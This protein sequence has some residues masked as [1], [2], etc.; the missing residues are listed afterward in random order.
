MIWE[1]REALFEAGDISDG[2]LMRGRN[3]Q[4][5][6]QGKSVQGTENSPTIRMNMACWRNSSTAGE[7]KENTVAQDENRQV[8][9]AFP[10][11]RRQI[12][13]YVEQ[14]DRIIVL[15]HGRI[16]GFDTHEALL[17]SNAVYQE[18][19]EIQTKGGGDFLLKALDKLFL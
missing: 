9:Q 16:S 2:I 7:R 3:K 5:V 14:A 18:I 15:E 8:Q 4:T 1:V 17:A 12:L 11:T 6:I 13:F 10:G 19:Y